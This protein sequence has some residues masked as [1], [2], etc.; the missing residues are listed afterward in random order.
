MYNELKTFVNL[1]FEKKDIYE[2]KINKKI[3]KRDSYISFFGEKGSFEKKPS[4]NWGVVCGAG[5]FSI[6]W[7]LCTIL[8]MQAI[9][10][11]IFIIISVIIFAI[12]IVGSVSVYRKETNKWEQI[13]NEYKTILEQKSAYQKNILDPKIKEYIIRLTEYYPFTLILLEKILKNE[14]TSFNEAVLFILS[15]K[16]NSTD[17]NIS[18]WKCNYCGCYQSLEELKCV[19][20]GAH[21]DDDA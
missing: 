2:F 15:K 20:C 16:N 19:C 17:R 7:I 8:T 9:N 21:R 3:R 10:K 1:C 4:F 6:V 13:N 18:F 5:I 11:R 12:A 14:L